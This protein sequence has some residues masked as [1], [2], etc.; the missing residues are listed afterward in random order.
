MA[1]VRDVAPAERQRMRW[2]PA[3]DLHARMRRIV[4]ALGFDHVDASRVYCLRVYGARA[5]A[6]ARIWGLPA[7]FQ[8]A[9]GVP[10]VYVVEFLC[11]AFDHLP[12][13]EQDRVIIHELLHI[14]TTFSG[15]VRPERSGSLR[16][17]RRTVERYYRRYRQAAA[18]APKDR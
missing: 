18:P 3:A 15:G 2:E 7:A 8:H 6:W 12:P 16:I 5:N 11:P 17:D 9:L 10:A 14:P 1:A 13:D 4:R